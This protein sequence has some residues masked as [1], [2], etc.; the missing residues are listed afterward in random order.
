VKDH[1]KRD[2]KVKADYPKLPVQVV[3]FNFTESDFNTIEIWLE[4][5]F[6]GLKDFESVP[7]DELPICSPEER[8][9]SGDKY[10]VMKKG[11]KTAM[12]VLD[13]KEEAEKWMKDNGGDHI[14]VR[15]GEDKKCLDYCA[16][17]EFCSYYKSLKGV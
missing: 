6:E 16:A 1:S 3:K 14:D 12:R 8:Y 10:A 13:S 9:N 4:L 11:R 2:A 15:S 7:D 17:C 5:E